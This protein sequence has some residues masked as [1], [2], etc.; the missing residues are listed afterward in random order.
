MGLGAKRVT[1]LVS[2]DMA[3]ALADFAARGNAV[4][5]AFVFYLFPVNQMSRLA[6]S[7]DLSLS[8][9]DQARTA[10]KANGLL[11]PLL[12]SARCKR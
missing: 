6:P 5:L 11:M 4:T 10:A 12:N 1:T 7:I 2:G 9:V 3:A 8:I